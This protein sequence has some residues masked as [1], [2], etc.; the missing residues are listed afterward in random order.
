MKERISYEEIVDLAYN[1]RPPEGGP[2]SR[3]ADP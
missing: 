1:A 3:P 2:A